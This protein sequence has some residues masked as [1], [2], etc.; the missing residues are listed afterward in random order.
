MFT[1]TGTNNSTYEATNIGV[2]DVLPSGYTLVS[3]TADLGAYNETT[4]TWEIPSIPV[5]TM[6][7][8]DND[9]DGDGC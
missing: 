1:I 3:H 6:A 2:E 4:G 5:G 8:L 9:R 7:S